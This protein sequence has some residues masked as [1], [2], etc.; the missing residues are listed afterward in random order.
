[1]SVASFHVRFRELTGM[2]PLNY[3]KSVRLHQARL[4]MARD[5]HSVATAAAAVGYVSASQF[6][7]EFKR[8][9]GRTASEEIRWMRA[10]LGELTQPV[11]EQPVEARK[12]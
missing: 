5:G 4:L 12:A 2:T 6:S 7:R 9:F 1:M 8:H 11:D 10:H 3:M